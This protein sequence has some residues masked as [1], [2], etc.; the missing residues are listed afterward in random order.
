[1]FK[2]VIMKQHFDDTILFVGQRN[3]IRVIAFTVDALCSECF[4]CVNN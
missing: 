3:L 4:N 1:M 2:T